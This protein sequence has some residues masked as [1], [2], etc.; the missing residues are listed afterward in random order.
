VKAEKGSKELKSLLDAN[1]NEESVIEIDQ[2]ALYEEE[3]DHHIEE[4][5]SW[6]SGRCGM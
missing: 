6:P 1:N 5:G 3:V 4:V 2:Q